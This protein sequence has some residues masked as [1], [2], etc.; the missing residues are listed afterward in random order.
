MSWSRAGVSGVVAWVLM[1]SSNST[2]CQPV[3]SPP[4][5][6]PAQ[7]A[8][9]VMAPVRVDPVLD[10]PPVGHALGIV[11][12]ALSATAPMRFVGLSEGEVTLGCTAGEQGCASWET[13]RQRLQVKPFALAEKE[14]T[15]RQWRVVMGGDGPAVASEGQGARPVAGL[16]WCDAVSFANRLSLQEGREPVFQGIEACAEGGVSWDLGAD[17]YRLPT[18]PEWEYAAR[19]GTTSRYWSGDR[20]EDLLRVGWIDKNAGEAHVVGEKPPNAWG[21][22]D[23]HGNVWEWA[24]TPFRLPGAS[25]D[26]PPDGVGAGV[27]RVVRGGGYWQG[28]VNGARSASRRLLSEGSRGWDW[29]RDFGLRLAFTL[30][31]GDRPGEVPGGR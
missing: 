20:R 6:P 30:E 9:Q 21:L 11:H 10:A 19:A 29:C 14:V 26:G 25:V 13:P 27:R 16:M 15:V 22:F 17:G 2:G 12:E 28:S 8:R 31:T 1:A 3:G 24:L 5:S 7:M 23:V 18:E 4:S